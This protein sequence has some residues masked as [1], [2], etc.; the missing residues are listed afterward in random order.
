LQFLNLGI[1]FGAVTIFALLAK[2]DLEKGSELNERVE[3]R[4]EK[5]K[6][7]QKLIQGMKDREMELSALQLAIQISPD[8][9][10]RDATVQELQSGAR[11]HMIIVAGPKKACRDALVGANL[12]KMDFAMSNVLVVPYETVS[13]EVERQTRPEGTGFADRP[14]YERQAYV[15]RAT[16]PGWDDYINTEMNDAVE[17]NGEK[18]RE[19]GIAIVVASTGKVLRRGVGKVPWRQ[20]VE[21][22][23][24]IVGGEKEKDVPWL[25]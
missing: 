1:D 3:E 12:L 9:T 7:Q 18:A 21:Q 5:K 4:L 15:A 23:D 2:Y 16:G 25:G 11:Q 22:L 20:M 10:T 6:E 13:N 24:E 14:I 8:G 17:Q 19:E